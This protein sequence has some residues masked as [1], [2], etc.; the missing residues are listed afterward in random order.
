MISNQD[1]LSKLR[2]YFD[3]NLYEVKIWTALL[4]KGDA[5]A[6]ELS[7]IANVPRSRSYDVLETLEKKGF[8]VQKIGK[9]IKYVAVSPSEV[10]EK[11]K[12]NI[13]E[14]ARKN[15]SRVD[16]LRNS[17]VIKE[18]NEIHTK[19]IQTMDISDLSTAVKGRHNL[20]NHLESTLMNA[21]DNV[22]IMTT[23][24]GFLRKSNSLRK[25]FEYLKNKGVKIRIAAPLTKTP[26]ATI[27][28]LSK[29]AEIKNVDKIDARFSI[30]DNKY[31]TFMM[32]D[33]EQVH[34]NYDTGIWVHSP[35]FA[36]ALNNLFDL[37]WK[38]LK[39]AK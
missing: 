28:E 33:D 1:N 27:D 21:Q 10:L 23:A 15:V 25:T 4:S 8:V 16:S 14:E 30:V 20:Y 38:D 18:L 19:G 3:L 2:R 22:T 5:T 39:K 11:V 13:D 9:P 17:D 31:V 32:A 7:D 26:K 36:T 35:F 37:A 24:A 6:G 12:K 29:F 34:P